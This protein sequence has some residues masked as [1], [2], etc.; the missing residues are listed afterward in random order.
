MLF[1]TNDKGKLYFRVCLFYL[2]I[3]LS[4]VCQSDMMKYDNSIEERKETYIIFDTLIQTI[5]SL[6]LLGAL[7]FLFHIS[8]F[9]VLFS[10]FFFKGSFFRVLF[11]WFFFHGSLFMVLFSW[12][13]FHG[14]F[15]CTMCKV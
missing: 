3:S 2:H 15:Q 1:Y 13:F 7:C 4:R 14:S 5:N 10:W 9:M 8:F 6:T 12:F 11:S